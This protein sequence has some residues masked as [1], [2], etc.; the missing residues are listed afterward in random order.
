MGAGPSF[1]PLQISVQQGSFVFDSLERTK[2]KPLLVSTDRAIFTRF[3]TCKYQ[4]QGQVR[5]AES[6]SSVTERP[7]AFLRDPVNPPQ[8]SKTL[9]LVPVLDTAAYRR[10][11]TNTVKNA[12]KGADG[13][14]LAPACP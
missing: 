9:T 3:M 2:G 13:R 4:H 10:R 12:E 6:E 11:E 8:H 1:G 14:D 7:G 5:E